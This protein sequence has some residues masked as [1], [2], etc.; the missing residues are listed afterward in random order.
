MDNVFCKYFYNACS[1]TKLQKEKSKQ[2]TN[3]KKTQLTW[4][5]LLTFIIL[6]SFKKV[7]AF[8][9]LHRKKKQHWESL[10]VFQL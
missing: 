9:K 8:L 1:E 5:D 4:H 3:K 7:I 2:R 10:S 6:V